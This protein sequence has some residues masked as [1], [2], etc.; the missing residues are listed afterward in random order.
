MAKDLLRLFARDRS[1]VVLIEALVV[2]PI[3]I[4][5]TVGILEFGNVMW[6]RQ[7]LQAGIR[8]AARYW[9]RCDLSATSNCSQTIAKNIA[10]YANPNPPDNAVPRVMGW[11][12]PTSITI[13]VQNF[14]TPDLTMSGPR[15]RVVVTG[16]ARYSGSPLIGFMPA[17]VGDMIYSHEERYIGW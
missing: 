2:F 8:D 3:L 17:T 12:D 15:R 1:G 13:E 7:Q 14:T 9:S 11:T 4:L 16:T 5:L 6:Q 10:L